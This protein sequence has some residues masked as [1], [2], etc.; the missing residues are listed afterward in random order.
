MEPL[1]ETDQTKLKEA[2]ENGKGNRRDLATTLKLSIMSCLPPSIASSLKI[3]PNVALVD[4]FMAVEKSLH[5]IPWIN[6]ANVDF[7]DL[8][9]TLVSDKRVEKKER[10]RLRALKIAENDI[11]AIFKECERQIT[12]I[13]T[14]AKMKGETYKQ[15]EPISFVWIKDEDRNGVLCTS[16]DG[17]SGK[18]YSIATDVPSNMRQNRQDTLFKSVVAELLRET[19]ETSP[20]SVSTSRIE[21]AYHQVGQRIAMF[22]RVQ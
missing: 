17:Q 4:Y 20:M 12:A 6:T 7:L 15:T 5:P 10:L 8:A 14:N 9:P 21:F 3:E 16:I 18:I 2:L 13:T 22:I 1:I 19:F 11:N